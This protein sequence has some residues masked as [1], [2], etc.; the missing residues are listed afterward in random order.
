MKKLIKYV[1][2]PGNTEDMATILKDELLK[3][4]CDIFPEMFVIEALAI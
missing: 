2:M 1:S 3:A 4:G